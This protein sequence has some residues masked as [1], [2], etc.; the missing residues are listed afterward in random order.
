M[1]KKNINIDLKNRIKNYLDYVWKE[2]QLENEEEEKIAINNLSTILK[3]ELLLESNS[4]IIQSIPILTKNF[5]FKFLDKITTQIKQIRKIPGEI[6]FEV[7]IKLKIFL[8]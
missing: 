6:L 1:N 5:S 7:L 8:F 2:E 4:R 3:E